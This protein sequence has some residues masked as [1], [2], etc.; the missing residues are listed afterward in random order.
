MQ[1]FGTDGIRFVVGPDKKYGDELV[2][3]HYLIFH[4]AIPAFRV[5]GAG[6]YAIVFDTRFSSSLISYLFSSVFAS[7]GANI[8]MCGILPT[9]AASALTISFGLGGAFSI[10]ASHN[11]PEFNGIKFFLK[12]GLKADRTT[13]EKIESEFSKLIQGDLPRFWENWEDDKSSKLSH[14]ILGNIKD[15]FHLTFSVYRSFLL[16]IAREKFLKGVKIVLDCANGSMYKIA[17]EVFSE[18][19]ADIVVIGNSP[20]GHNINV[21]VGSE[22]PA[23]ALETEGDF[24]IIFDGDGDRVLI[25][26]KNGI[27][28]DG[29]HIISL[30]ARFMKEEGNLKWGI[31]GTILSNMALEIFAKEMGIGFERVDVGDR[32]IAYKM[33]ELGANLGGEESGHII[34]S[35]FLPTGDGMLCAIKTLFYIMK[36]EKDI[37]QLVINKFHQSKGKVNVKEKKPLDSEDFTFVRKIVDEVKRKNGRAVIRYSG[38]EPVIRVMVEHEDKEVAEKFCHDI[39]EELKK[40]FHNNE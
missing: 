28:Y 16:S 29:D 12:H 31:V 37:S 23:K 27:L 32:N 18:L 21:G 4:I 33:R 8:L 39:V 5:L 20:N 26:D 7:C 9:P 2:F 15:A 22:E 6:K 24:K 11:P 38:T 30:L 36:S 35:D 3:S 17:P 19:G 34:L 40:I 25:G 14:S 10:S 1:L 13:E